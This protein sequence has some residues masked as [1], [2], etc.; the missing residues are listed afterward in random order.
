M[1]HFGSKGWLVKQLKEAGVTRHPIERRKLEIYK[2]SILY[3]LYQ[4]YVLKGK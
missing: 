1:A 2:A 4:K 3:G